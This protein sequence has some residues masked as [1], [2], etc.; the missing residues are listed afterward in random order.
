MK[1]LRFGIAGCG[2][3]CNTHIEALQCIEGVTIAG[4]CSR[5]RGRAEAAAE[6]S[7]G[8]L[9][10]SYEEMIADPQVDVVLILTASGMHADMGIQAAKA[11]KHVIVEKPIDVFVEKAEA[12]VQACEEAGV[13][14][15]CIFQHR[16]DEDVAALKAAIQEGKLGQLYGGCCHTKWYRPQEYYDMVDWRGTLALDGGGALMNQ[17][18]HQLDLFQYLLGD[19]EEVFAYKG[20][21]GH[22]RIET[23]DLCVAALKFKSGAIGLMEASTVAKPGFDTRIDVNGEKG[24]VVLR[25]NVAAHWC[26][27]G[28]EPRTAHVTGDAHRRQLQE[29]ADSIREGRPSLV[30][31]KEALKALRIAAAI[32]RSAES[33]KPEKV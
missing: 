10:E 7:G 19:V 33:G 13:S 24:S 20:T 15:S 23:E 8:R 16:Y 28:E 26:I 12:L 3:I 9:Y 17:G 18:I 6:K 14:L 11:G 25:D 32:Y 27:D 30:S 2:A 31:G 22:E 29:I 21:F 4:V 1:Q 5:G